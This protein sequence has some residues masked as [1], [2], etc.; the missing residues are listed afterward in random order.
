[1][2]AKLNVNCFK[3]DEGKEDTV[4][5][6]HCLCADI[7]IFNAV[8]TPLPPARTADGDYISKRGNIIFCLSL[9]PRL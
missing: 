9:H 5:D 4:T 8:P 2:L 7:E 1:M 3:W 6:D